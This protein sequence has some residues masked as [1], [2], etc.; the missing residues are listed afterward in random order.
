[1]SSNF[2]RLK[3]APRSLGIIDPNPTVVFG[4]RAQRIAEKHRLRSSV[5][6][7]EYDHQR[8]VGFLYQSDL[9]NCDM[10]GCIDLFEGIS[11]EVR[12]IFTWSGD[13]RDTGYQKLKGVWASD[14]SPRT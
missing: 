6:R 12:K 14:R 7:I 10:G 13:V 11:P 2:R 5:E 4:A 8:E 9:N 1:M 3:E